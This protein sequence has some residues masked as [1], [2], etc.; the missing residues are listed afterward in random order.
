MLSSRD[1]SIPDQLAFTYR[2][3]IVLAYR[4]MGRG[5]TTVRWDGTRRDKVG[6]DGRGW[7]DSG[8]GWDKAG[9]GGT[10][11]LYYYQLQ[12]EP[13]IQKHIY[14]FPLSVNLPTHHYI[15]ISTRNLFTGR[16]RKERRGFKA[17]RRRYPS[18]GRRWVL[19]PIAD[20]HD[21][22]E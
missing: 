15:I 2:F 16:S 4:W 20:S 22:G 11:V 9:R 18:G 6:W 7:D 17:R 12:N 10:T 5:G 13:V 19:R 8:T 21:R 14:F 3:L 1:V